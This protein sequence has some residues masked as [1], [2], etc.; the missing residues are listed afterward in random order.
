MTSTYLWP[1]ISERISNIWKKQLLKNKREDYTEVAN[2]KS[3]SN[4][5]FHILL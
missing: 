1:Q 2:F 3:G 5:L 4:I